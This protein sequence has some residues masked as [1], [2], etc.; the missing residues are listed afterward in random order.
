MQ[1]LI[2]IGVNL[3]DK[4]FNNDREKVID[5]AIQNGVVQMILTGSSLKSSRQAL[6]IA[7]QYPNILFS[8]AGIHPHDAKTFT[9]ETIGE[10]EKLAQHKEVVAI[11]ECGLDF[12][13][14]Y[15]PQDVQEECFEA[16]LHLAR[17]LSMPLFLHERDAHERFCE[18]FANFRDLAETSVVHCF[19]GD[20]EQVKKYVSMGFYIGLTGW[21]CDERRGRDLQNAVKYIPLDRLLIETDAPYLLP[22]NLENKPKNR[23]NEPAFLPHIAKEIA[24]YMGVEPEIVAKHATENTRKLFNLPEC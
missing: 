9:S 6:E 13:R 16:Q 10:L 24:K 15:S 2:D 12:N 17:K 22:R 5:R 14:M 23:R 21:I 11:G 19:T 18:I 7:K 1:Y 3:T 4:H 8:T 20:E